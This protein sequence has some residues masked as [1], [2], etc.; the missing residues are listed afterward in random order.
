MSRSRPQRKKL[1]EAGARSP[2]NVEILRPVYSLTT[3]TL[4]LDILVCRLQMYNA[5]LIPVRKGLPHHFHKTK[6]R[7]ETSDEKLPYNTPASV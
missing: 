1:S 5:F 7:P 6:L 4:M 2:V 3:Y